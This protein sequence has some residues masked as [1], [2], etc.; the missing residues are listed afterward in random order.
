MQDLDGG[1]KSV[2][3]CCRIDGRHA[4]ESEYGIQTPF[5]IQERALPKLCS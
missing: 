2:A 1:A 5:A 3:V 4:A